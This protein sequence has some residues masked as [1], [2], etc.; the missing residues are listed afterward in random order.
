MGLTSVIPLGPPGP[1]LSSPQIPQRHLDRSLRSPGQQF[2][3]AQLTRSGKNAPSALPFATR[4]GSPTQRGR[5]A[6]GAFYAIESRPL[7]LTGANCRPGSRADLDHIPKN[8]PRCLPGQ[9]R[10]ARARQQR[11]RSS[12]RNPPLPRHSS[13]APGSSGAVRSRQ[14]SEIAR[15]AVRAGAANA[16]GEKRAFRPA[17]R[18]P[19]WVPNPARPSRCRRVLRDRVP[20]AHAD[21]REPL[22]GLSS[23][24]GRTLRRMTCC[25]PG[26]QSDH[27]EA[28]ESSGTRNFPALHQHWCR[29]A[30]SFCSNSG[31]RIVRDVGTGNAPLTVSW[32]LRPALPRRSK[33][34]ARFR[35]TRSFRSQ[36]SRRH[37]RSRLTRRRNR[38]GLLGQQKKG[39]DELAD[40]FAEGRDRCAER[41]AS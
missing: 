35:S 14:I 18:D 28:K 1:H 29:I 2:A 36:S 32:W 13:R 41:V 17:A 5:H 11:S 27:P 7:T 33:G 22:P 38:S 15:A 10:R 19:R 24:S 30:D 37:T 6:A 40:F 21:R 26:T 4:A 39:R 34:S 8:D 3:P 16:V 12:P 25:P 31:D 23:R 20:P 9:C